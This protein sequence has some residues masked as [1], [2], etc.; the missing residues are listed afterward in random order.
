MPTETKIQA[1]QT[2]ATDLAASRAAGKTIVLCHGVF[3]LLHV[4]HIKHLQAAKDLGDILVVTLTPDHY[5]NKG[6]H[7]PAF[8]QQL[9]ADA[10]AALA[11]VDHV[12][13]NEWP[14]AVET[15][16]L[17]RPHVYCKGAVKEPPGPRDHTG[18]I[19]AEEDA[20]REVGGRLHLTDEDTF[21][22]T[23]LINTHLDILP[24]DVKAFLQDFR[25]RHTAAEI[26]GLIRAIRPLRI[27]VIGEIILDEYHF[28]EVMN[29]SNKEP[30]LAAQFR[31]AETYAGGILAI[32]RHLAGFADSVSAL[33]FLGDRD[34]QEDFVRKSLSASVHLHAFPKSDSPTIVKRRFLEEYLAQKLFE[35]YEINAD[36]LTAADEARFLDQL[37]ELLPQQD[38]VIVADY[39][40]GLFTENAIERI[41]AR[42]PFLAVNA[43]T[44]AG[45]RGFN[46]VSKYSRAD[47]VA[48]DRPEAQ[49][50]VRNRKAGIEDLIRIMADRIDCPRFLVTCGKDGTVGYSR[51]QG[52]CRVP[53]LAVK[54]V[55]R[56]GAGDAF[57]SLAAPC[58]ALGAAM[59]VVGLVGNMAGAAKC[60]IMGNREAIEPISFLRYVSALVT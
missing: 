43:Q 47:I 17:L 13:I 59:E 57:L 36:P 55:D 58:A 25:A 46:C 56:M 50:E 39:G 45:N 51:E 5:V 34:A 6:P 19:V 12:A 2:L 60:G 41:C 14:T 44:N 49:L 26:T 38:V 10:L 32:A 52:Y 29:K 9:R 23:A 15:I 33:S 11:C 4:G 8:P 53:A 7:R 18:A 3:D 35:V 21:S 37:D 30:I 27:L 40:H 16:R 24:P 22:A 42:A 54:M 1:L 28:C 48:I 31:H 20:V